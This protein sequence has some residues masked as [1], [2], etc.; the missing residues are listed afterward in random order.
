M[1]RTVLC[2]TI[3]YYVFRTDPLLKLWLHN[4][5]FNLDQ[6]EAFQSYLECMDLV[7]VLRH[8]KV[9]LPGFTGPAMYADP[10]D[11]PC[12]IKEK[13]SKRDAVPSHLLDVLLPH[14]WLGRRIGSSIFISDDSRLARKRAYMAALDDEELEWCVTR[15]FQHHPFPGDESGKTPLHLTCLEHCC[16]VTFHVH[17]GRPHDNEEEWTDL[18]K[19]CHA[20]TDTLHSVATLRRCEPSK[21]RLRRLVRC[22]WN[23][24][25]T[26][27]RGMLVAW[28]RAGMCMDD[29]FAEFMHNLFGMTLQW[30]YALFRMIQTNV[31]VR[32]VGD[33]M[34]MMVNDPPATTAASRCPFTN[35][36]VLHDLKA[37][38]AHADRPS[39]PPS[40]SPCSSPLLA[41][42]PKSGALAWTGHPIQDEDPHYVPFG[43]GE[44]R[45][46]GEYLTYL[47]LIHT[48]ASLTTTTP[49]PEDRPLR[50]ERLGLRR[51]P[52]CTPA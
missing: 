40:L 38:C 39:T 27:Q 21:R 50:F 33:A 4:L 43:C 31:R 28:R 1:L 47:F 34:R 17:F 46:P 36:T 22:L 32:T 20:I 16:K 35:G 51:V 2:A 19:I 6:L 5:R 24:S 3:L 42:L 48:N 45:C 18:L 15:V 23:A 12:D 26:K 44:R 11:L 13:W 25:S 9:I 7:D 14:D 8:V 41:L 52:V 30:S 49:V 29:A 37:V 10:L